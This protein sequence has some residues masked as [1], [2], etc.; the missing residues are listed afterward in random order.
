MFH[1]KKKDV[2]AHYLRVWDFIGH[3]LVSAFSSYQYLDTFLL[4]CLLA[5]NTWVRKRVRPYTNAF[6]TSQRKMRR[7]ERYTV[8]HKANGKV[9]LSC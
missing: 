1:D 4:I 5:Y 8:E 2:R 3:T 9:E 7:I 6:F